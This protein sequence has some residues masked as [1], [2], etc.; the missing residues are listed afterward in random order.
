[1]LE[2]APP[3]GAS[4]GWKLA[5]TGDR[6]S[7]EEVHR[8]VAVPVGG[9]WVRRLLAFARDLINSDRAGHMV[10]F[11]LF[12]QSPPFAHLNAVYMNFDPSN[13]LQLV[14]NAAD[15]SDN[16]MGQWQKR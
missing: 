6:P 8:S 13:A 16:V 14:K 9:S 12:A 7:L 11:E 4:G 3:P 15:L 10:T 5:R 1:M 2:K